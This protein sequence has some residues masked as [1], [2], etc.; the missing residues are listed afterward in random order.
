MGE[1]FRSH[2]RRRKF[3]AALPFGII[4]ILATAIGV[5][6]YGKYW[7]HPAPRLPTVIG[8]TVIGNVEP[9]P[10]IAGRASVID[11]DTIE[12]QGTRIR[13]FGIDAPESGQQC[14]VAG[15]ASRCGQQA[16]FVLS[17]KIGNRPVEC[18]RKDT[19]R[20]GRMVAVCAVGGEDLSAWLVSQGWALAYRYYSETYVPHESAASR[21]KRGMW[22]D[23]SLMAGAEQPAPASTMLQIA[24]R[25]CL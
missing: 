1:S 9:Q 18:R 16:A 25:H 15:K 10:T 24:P 5:V 4:A 12:I 20:Y 11:G 13:L 7:P 2:R 17:D 3:V 22:R 14:T 6:A 19:D 23:R 21:A 8:N